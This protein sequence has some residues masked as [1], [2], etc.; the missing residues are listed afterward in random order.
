MTVHRIMAPDW[1]AGHE[2]RAIVWNDETGEATGDHHYVP[3]LARAL[4]GPT[5]LVQDRTPWP[6]YRLEDP[7][8]DPAD[9]LALI[10]VIGRLGV[11]YPERVRLPESLRG[12]E[13]T[14]SLPD[15]T[16]PGCLN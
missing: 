5:P 2:L 8:H 16:P 12:V 14:P 10:L 7:A 4:A 3:T 9:F 1:E 11:P 6:H 13:P 15:D